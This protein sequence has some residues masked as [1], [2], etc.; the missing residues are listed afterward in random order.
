MDPNTETQRDIRRP[1][2][3]IRERRGDAHHHPQLDMA[4]ASRLKE[5]FQELADRGLTE[6]IVDALMVSFLDSTGLHALVAGKR[7]IHEAGSNLAL[8]VSPQV[9]HVLELV[10]PEHL[11]AARVDSMEQVREALGWS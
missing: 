1:G 6:V 7:V 8:V 5:A 10:F 2:R 11:F 4:T 9:R 3:S